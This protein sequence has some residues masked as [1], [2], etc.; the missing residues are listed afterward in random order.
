MNINKTSLI[1]AAIDAA[2]H[3]YSPY[4]GFKVGAAILGSDGIIY[5]GCNVENASYGLTI[6]AERTAAVKMVSCGC[7]K[8]AAMA[9]YCNAGDSC[10][11]CGACRQLLIEFAAQ[12]T[13]IYTQ[14]NKLQQDF[15]MAELLPHAF[16][17]AFDEKI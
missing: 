11:P 1:N 14:G 3:A 10:M 9:V 4:S 7:Q 12:D 2:E 17:G 6:C 8:I 15:T 13:P 16:S 5:T